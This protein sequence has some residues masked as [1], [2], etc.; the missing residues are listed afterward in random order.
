M[1][2]VQLPSRLAAA[3]QAIREHSP[4]GNLLLSATNPEN[5]R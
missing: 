3:A 2:T 4:P 5:G 1:A